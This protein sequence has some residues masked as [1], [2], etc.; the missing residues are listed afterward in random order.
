M[1]EVVRHADLATT[2]D[3]MIAVG[4]EVEVSSLGPEIP[5]YAEAT[6]FANG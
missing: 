2:S 6:I 5:C 4:L 1:E 3:D